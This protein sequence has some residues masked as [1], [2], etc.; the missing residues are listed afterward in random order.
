TKIL[1]VK[2]CIATGNCTDALFT[3]LKSL[4]VKPGD[5]IITPAFSWIASAQTIS[6]CG[7]TPVFVDVDAEMYTLDPA[8]V[9]E[10]ITPKTRGII[11]VHLY[12]QAAQATQIKSICAKH[13]LFMIEDCAQ[14]HLTKEEER[15]AGVIGDV[16]AFSFYPTKNLGAYGDAGCI[17]TH[18]DDLAVYMRRFANN[19]AL[20]KD[21]HLLEGSN[22]RM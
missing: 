3:A 21:D 12:G 7:A 2:N 19:G 1:G 16:G 17:V 11:V 8:L 15:C 6:L 9:E 22:S 18:D 20:V 13:Q 10:K 14:A 5:E 4:G